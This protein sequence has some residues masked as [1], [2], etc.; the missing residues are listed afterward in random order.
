MATAIPLYSSDNG[1]SQSH[2]RSKPSEKHLPCII[3][4]CHR[5]FVQVYSSTVVLF[6]DTSCPVN[7]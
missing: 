3:C 2:A 1:K 7:R 6:N 4:P 5:C